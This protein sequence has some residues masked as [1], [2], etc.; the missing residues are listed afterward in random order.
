VEAVM[1]EEFESIIRKNTWE[2]FEFPEGKIPIG[3]KW[4]YKLKFNVDGS[5]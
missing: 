3:C 2:L 4:L 1:N 5:I